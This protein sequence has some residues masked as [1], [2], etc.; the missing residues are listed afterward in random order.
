VS[1][2]GASTASLLSAAQAILA[3]RTATNLRCPVAK[4]LAAMPTDQ[5]DELR[6][7][8]LMDKREMPAAVIVQVLA[9][10]GYAI[11]EDPILSHRRTLRGG[12]G[13]KCRS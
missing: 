1:E 4:M 2:S 10:A 8:L 5:A 11:T 6:T 7:L 9:D 3:E 13:C 12:M